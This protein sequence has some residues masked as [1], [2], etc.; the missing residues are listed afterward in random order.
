[1]G[2]RIWVMNSDG[3]GQRR[4]TNDPGFADLA[5]AWSPDG[6]RIV[7]SQCDD[8][9]GFIAGC[10][11]ELMT[12][13]GTGVRAAGRWPLDL[14]PRR[15]FPGRAAHCR[16]VGPRRFPWRPVGNA[17]RR[18]GPAP[19]HQAVAPGVLAGLVPRRPPHPVHRQL[20]SVREQRLDGALRRGKGCGSSPTFGPAPLQGG[21][22]SYSPDGKQIVLHSTTGNARR[23]ESASTSTS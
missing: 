16:R 7:F 19:D 23:G 5:P 4:L 22:A 10:D 1:M 11:L 17:F 8:H 21:F 3:S 6:A 14:G 12:A 20:L 18:D 13:A 9:L 2:S 15:V